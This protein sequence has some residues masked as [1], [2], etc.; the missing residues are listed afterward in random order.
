MAKTNIPLLISLIIISVLIL[1]FGFLQIRGA[2]FAPFFRPPAPKELT[3]AEILAELRTRDTDKDRL[4]DFDEKFIHATSP[5]IADTDS[6]G[7]SDYEEVMAGSNPLDPASTPYNKKEVSEESPL[8][9]TFELPEEQGFV[10]GKGP[11]AEE[12]RNLLVTRGGLSR[13]VVDNLDDKTLIKLYNETK[14]ETGIDLERLEVPQEVE[15]LFSNLDITELRRL[16]I[17]EGADPEMLEKLD[18]ETLRLLFLQA[19]QQQF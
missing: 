16:L 9:K 3:Q 14:E 13:E 7:F 5:Y 15:R 12:I 2:I 10:P 4:S 11:S 1:G 17:K 8:E 18:D 6:D 19:F